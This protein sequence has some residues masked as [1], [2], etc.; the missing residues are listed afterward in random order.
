[1]RTGVRIGI[2]LGEVRIGVA[3]SDV[4][5]QLCLPLETVYRSGGQEIF[6]IADLVEEYQAFEIVIGLPRLLSGAEGKNARDVRH[7]GKE[8]AEVLPNCNVRLVDERLT[9]V[10]AHGQL[11][12]A[13]V[14]ARRQRK[15]VDQQ[16]AVLILEQAL[17]VEKNTG[18]APGIA[19]SEGNTGKEDK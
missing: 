4:T 15:I 9:S 1:M 8:L 7:W 3:R 19:L 17:A 10:S 2:D 13:G 18:A 14:S 16:A 6:E 5:G 11:S 12:Q